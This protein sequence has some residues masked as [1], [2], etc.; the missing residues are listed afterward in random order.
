MLQKAAAS[1]RH[2][3]K[4][5]YELDAPY[6][7]VSDKVKSVLKEFFIPFVRL[8]SK[9]AGYAVSLIKAGAD[10]IGKPAGSVRAPLVMPSEEEKN[11]LQFLIDKAKILMV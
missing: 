11:E 5:K 10:I 7:E 3:A 2:H 4:I 8:R 1:M 6:L 9:K